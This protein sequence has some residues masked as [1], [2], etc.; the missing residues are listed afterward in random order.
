MI[1]YSYSN[2][3]IDK[4]LRDETCKNIYID[5][6]KIM[7]LYESTKIEDNMYDLIQKYNEH[8]LVYYFLGYYYGTINKLDLA[9]ASYKVC[10][11][12]YPLADAYLNLA[13]IYQQ[14]GQL[15]LAKKIIEMSLNYESNKDDLRILN[16]IGTS[17]YIDKNFDKAI[18]HYKK[19]ISIHFSETLNMKNI[20]NNLGFSCSAVGKC[21]KALK[22]FED[23][24][25]INSEQSPE[26][27]K[28]DLQLL[29]NKLIN[30]DYMIDEQENVFNEFLRINDFLKPK[31]ECKN[32]LDKT[33]NHRIKVGY[34][35]PDLRH[36]VCAYFIDPILKY[37]DR[38][39]FEVYCYANVMKEDDMSEHFKSYP[40]I[41]WFNI[42]DMSTNDAY[43]LILS[44]KID[45]LVDLAG[46]TNNNRLDVFAEKAAP[47]QMT[48]LGYPNTTGLTNMDFRITDR[49][50]DPID[51][52]QKY[53][54]K[55]IY[56]PRCFI[57][58]TPTMNS[59]IDFDK[60][61]I[62]P[63]KHKNIT[64]G[65]FNKLNKYNKYTFQI[66]KKILDAI[67]TA[68]LLIKRGKNKYLSKS[69]INEKQIKF[70]EYIK[71]QREYYSL[72]N[73]VDICLDTFPYSGTTT[74]CD[75]LIMSTPIITLSIPNRH[76]SNV[77]KSLLTNIG[78]PE[79]VANSMEDYVRIAVNL[80][81]D[82]EKI[83]NYKQN[84]RQNFYELMNAKKFSKEF[85]DLM[86]CTYQDFI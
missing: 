55:L 41:K 51:T 16:F 66:W 8:Y 31:L 7:F 82:K 58:Y 38:N 65:V 60:I 69:G 84:I 9:I 37:Y 76:V 36:H 78:F 53:S 79:L 42:F 40:E 52:Q 29:Q 4:M 20:Y 81:N 45:I 15:E 74:S 34:V 56:M 24:L 12:K 39:K 64:F 10:L 27:I 73:D 1:V 57:C 48:Y 75:A 5:T 83:I 54:E 3:N 43:N 35:S 26:R 70:M 63:I 18:E 46:H 13:I 28:M 30:Y 2:D 85:D 77:T 86:Q 61:P 67:P 11:L 6:H 62:I 44:H 17:Y 19:I 72:Y 22:Y 71:D 50:A 23:G 33:K 32:K 49:L 25:K 80:A 59:N 14:C 47:I 68:S 21:D